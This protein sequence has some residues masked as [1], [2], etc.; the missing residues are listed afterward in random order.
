M[1]VLQGGPDSNR[2]G[3]L[4]RGETWTQTSGREPCGCRG[5]RVEDAAADRVDQKPVREEERCYP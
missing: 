5:Q 4:L 1:E 2:T 3:V